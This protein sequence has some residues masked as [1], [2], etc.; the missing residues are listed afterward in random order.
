MLG[1]VTAIRTSLATALT[2]L[3]LALM[4]YLLHVGVE[5]QS[6]VRVYGICLMLIAAGAFCITPL[7]TL[8]DETSAVKHKNTLQDDGV[9]T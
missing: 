7:R 9:S 5:L 8:T 3:S 4:S 2:P 6:V 1:K